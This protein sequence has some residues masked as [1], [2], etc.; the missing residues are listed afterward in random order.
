[1]GKK[2]N[3]NGGNKHKKYAKEREQIV[4]LNIFELDKS[5]DQEFAFVDRVLG[6]KRFE[7]ICYDK[8]R[9]VGLVRASKSN[10]S[11]RKNWV[12]AQS[13][14]LISL[15]TFTTVD[16]KC[17]IIKLYNN[18][19]VN[20]LLKHKKIHSNFVKSGSFIHET[21]T[22]SDMC[23]F[24]EDYTKP[25]HKKKEE[26][27]YDNVYMISDDEDDNG[28]DE[29]KN[30]EIRQSKQVKKGDIDIENI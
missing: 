15:R 10:M 26:R 14:V 18:D 2:S 13:L 11:K 17:D 21:N 7:L 5:K 29:E 27:N 20:F 23:S 19:E 8:K 9:R 4:R 28:Y 1:M 30:N 16:D 25:I 6:N 24:I 12:S 22:T 3:I